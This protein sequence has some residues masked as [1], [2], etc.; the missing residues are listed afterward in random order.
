MES[1]LVLD[2]FLSQKYRK[3][4]AKNLTLVTPVIMFLIWEATVMQLV[5]C[6]LPANHIWSL[7]TSFFF[8][9]RPFMISKLICLKFFLR[10]PL[11]PLTVSSLFLN[12][13]STK[14]KCEWDEV[15]GRL[16]VGG[17]GDFF[18]SKNVFH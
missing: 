8:L 17:D 14:G 6:F 9:L 7:R 15:G 18:F 10:V 12:E 4:I 3:I 1:I 13:T 5:F 16:T 11:G 2:F